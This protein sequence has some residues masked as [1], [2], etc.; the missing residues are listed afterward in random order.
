MTLLV[1]DFIV[2]TESVLWRM[3]ADIMKIMKTYFSHKND[4]TIITFLS[5]DVVITPVA[6]IVAHLLHT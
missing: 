6:V 5:R 4:D 2:S 1:W 3:K